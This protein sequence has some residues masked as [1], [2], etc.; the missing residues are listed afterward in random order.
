MKKYDNEEIVTNRYCKQCGRDY[1]SQLFQFIDLCNAC[2]D[3][4]YPP[5]GL[6]LLRQFWQEKIVPE[7]PRH[8]NESNAEWIVRVN[9]ATEKPKK[10]RRTNKR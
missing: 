2:Y 8:E 6:E 4:L 5:K 7:Y 3:K 10:Y 1:E 9:K